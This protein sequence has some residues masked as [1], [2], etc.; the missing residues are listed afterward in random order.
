MADLDNFFNLNKVTTDDYRESMAHAVG[1][2]GSIAKVAKMAF[3]DQGEA[4]ENGN[5]VPPTSTGTLN[6]VVLVKPITSVT[7]PEPYTVCFTC[8]IEAGETTASINEVA[9]LDADDNTL[10]KIRLFNA[11]G[12]DDETGLAFKWKMEF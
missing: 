4:D 3:G 11:K 10:A 12:V 2:T 8:E 9:L 1:S 7:Y 5:P 6:N